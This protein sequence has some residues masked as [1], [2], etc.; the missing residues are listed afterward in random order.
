MFCI[1]YLFT[2][3]LPPKPFI[4]SSRSKQSFEPNW[5]GEPPPTG[6]RS[7]FE[8]LSQLC[9]NFFATLSQLFLS[10]LVGQIMNKL[11]ENI[12]I[13]IYIYRDVCMY[14]YIYIYMSQ[15]DEAVR[16]SG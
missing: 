13:H 5:R 10:Q 6:F 8:T 7:S 12:Y 9:R 4:R 3:N 1:F 15:L 16:R 2:P 14:I 11:D